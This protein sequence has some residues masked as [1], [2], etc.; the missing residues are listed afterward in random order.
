[1]KKNPR[2]FERLK[3]LPERERQMQLEGRW[4]VFEGQALPDWNPD[5]HI[6]P[7]RDP[8]RNS[9]KFISV[10]WGFTKPFSVSWYEVDNYDRLYKY[11]EWYGAKYD[12]EG[13]VRPNVGMEMDAF[14]VAQGVRQRTME[15]VSYM[16]EDP[17]M[18]DKFGHGGGSIADEFRKVLRIP[19]V[20]GNNDRMQ[21]K[22]QI[23]SRL[24]LRADGVP[25]L[26]VSSRCIHTIRVLPALP[27]SQTNP[28]DV[29]TKSEDHIYDDLRYACMSQP[30]TEIVV[31]GREG[32]KTLTE[33]EPFRAM[34]PKR[35]DKYGLV[36]S[37][38]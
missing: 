25:G 31:A 36:G 5:I 28:E 1:M 12:E 22:N 14:T 20:R 30:T 35:E 33:I 17:H 37:Y 32:L 27:I 18:E 26:T 21:G 29:D 9:I 8:D 13:K 2:Y 19:I 15:S 38:V 10:D 24:R 16:V 3:G 4:D 34:K 7:H 11:R 23:H 6:V